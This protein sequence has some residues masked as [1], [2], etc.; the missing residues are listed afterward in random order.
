MGDMRRS[1]KH[2][3]S[4]SG[5]ANSLTTAKRAGHWSSFWSAGDVSLVLLAV[6]VVVVVLLNIVDDKLKVVRR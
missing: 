1:D 3:V 4:T 5:M 6:L 2:T